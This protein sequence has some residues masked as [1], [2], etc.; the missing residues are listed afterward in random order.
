MNVEKIFLGIDQAIPCGLIIS[1]L[2]SNAIKYA[3]PRKHR[4]KGKIRITFN[5]KGK[6]TIQLVVEDDGIGI[7]D[8]VDITKVDSLG[9]QMVNLLAEKQLKGKLK[10]DRE[11][12]T[13][14]TIS[15]SLP[16][17]SSPSVIP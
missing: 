8:V 14:F 1:E 13:K 12:G 3:F 5:K 2:V 10:L 15:F 11:R 16:E 17:N 7:P 9:L 4:K 6:R